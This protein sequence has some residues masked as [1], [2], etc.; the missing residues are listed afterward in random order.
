MLDLA[1]IHNSTGLVLISHVMKKIK[2]ADATVLSWLL[3][4]LIL[5]LIL[6][7]GAMYR[8]DDPQH[9]KLLQYDNTVLTAQT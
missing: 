6:Q 8:T 4:S 2:Y 9:S 5:M 3:Q 7:G 1:H